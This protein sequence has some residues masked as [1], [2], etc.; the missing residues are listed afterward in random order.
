M[1]TTQQVRYG[2]NVALAL[3]F[4]A[5]FVV[6]LFLLVAEIRILNQRINELNT[7]AIDIDKEVTKITSF[8]G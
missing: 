5:A 8:F 2:I 6:M 1:A 7:T 4:L 3:G